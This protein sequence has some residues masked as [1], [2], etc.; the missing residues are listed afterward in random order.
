MIVGTAG[1]IDHGKTALVKALTGVDADRLKEEKARGITIDLGYA[2]SDL[3]DGRQLG[4]VDVPGHERFVHNMLAGATGIDA[5]LLVVSAAEGIKPQTVEHLQIMDLLGLDRG[6]VALTKSDLVNDDELLERM[7]EVETLLSSTS[8]AGAE[9]IPVSAMTGA[10]VDELKAKLLALGESGKGASG[11][12]RLAVDRCFLLSGAGVVVTGTVHAGE[13]KVGDHLLLAPSGLEARVRSLHAQNRAAEVGHAGERCALNLSGARLSKDVVKRGDW[14]VS[15]ELQAPTD[16]I[17]VELK[18]LA[19][20]KDPL[21][22]WAPVHIHLGA[23]HVM[24]RVAL[25]EGDRLVPGASGLGAARARGEDRRAG[26][27]PGD[28]ARSLG[29]AHD[30]GR[31]DRRSVRA[32][33]Q[34]APA[35]ASRRAARAARAERE[36]AAGAAAGRDR[37]RRPRALRRRPQSASGRS[38]AAAEPR[39]AA[40]RWRASASSP[41]RWRRRAP[42]SWPP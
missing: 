24:G 3:G 6:I 34:P 23:A 22:H 13:I 9:I 12:A 39:P 40:P 18:V 41:R 33:A 14:V 20:E 7:A 25:L 42:T 21:K 36:R 31:A 28:P 37:L 30:G 1:H 38:G 26:G 27:R 5:A 16:R 11:Y 17:D 32:A 2:Y 15:P 10:G 35:A 19:S 4:F 29:H 8:L